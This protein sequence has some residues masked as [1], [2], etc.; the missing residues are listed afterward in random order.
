MSTRSEAITL[1]IHEPYLTLPEIGKRL[2]VSKQR[3][4]TILK[5]EG[6]PTKGIY[7]RKIL[8]YCPVCHNPTPNKQS[9]CPGKCKEAIKFI[10]TA[11]EFC[12]VVFQRK[13]RIIKDSYKRG[14]LHIF[15]STSCYNKAQRDG[16]I[17][18]L[19]L[20]SMKKKSRYGSRRAESNAFTS[21]YR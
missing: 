19:S 21:S 6:M 10:L 4:F 5:Q 20:D 18:K 3:I 12:H 8:V 14:Y 13:K 15:C 1:R 17:R 2:G 11:C 7:Q 9:V 16:L